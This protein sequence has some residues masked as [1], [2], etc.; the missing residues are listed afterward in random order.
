MP[1]LTDQVHLAPVK[2]CQFI[3]LPPTLPDPERMPPPQPA[4]LLS[5]ALPSWPRCPGPQCPSATPAPARDEEL[6][7]LARGGERPPSALARSPGCSSPRPT[8]AG[9]LWDIGLFSYNSPPGLPGPPGIS[10]STCLGGGGGEAGICICSMQ[11]GHPGSLYVPSL[12]LSLGWEGPSGQ[13]N[14]RPLAPYGVSQGSCPALPF[15]TSSNP[16]G[17]K[18]ACGLE[19]QL[20]SIKGVANGGTKTIKI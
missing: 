4:V 20:L 11:P 8:E 18:I 10:H 17:A 3:A 7:S 14:P 2:C 16:S 12:W 9:D 19:M 15:Q 13:G 5:W 6:L 1:G